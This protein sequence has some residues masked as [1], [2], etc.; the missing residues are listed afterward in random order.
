MAWLQK[1]RQSQN[2][3]VCIWLPNQKRKKMISTG[4]SNKKIAEK[5]LDRINEIE[6]LRKT[7]EKF[8]RLL[9][10]DIQYDKLILKD[11][12][13]MHGIDKTITLGA[14]S[15]TFLKSKGPKIKKGTLQSYKQSVNDLCTSLGNSKR[16]NEIKKQ[17]Y[18]ILLSFLMN[19]YVPTTVNIRQ[20]SIKTFF[21]WCIEYDYLD[22][23]PFKIKMLKIEQLPKFLMP[24][25][26][27]G[28]Y[29]YV[30]DEVMAAI[31]RMY[32]STGMRLSELYS[33]QYGGNYL[34]IVGKGGKV[35]FIPFDKDNEQNFQIAIASGYSTDKISRAFTIT[36]RKH[37]IHQNPQYLKGQ[38]VN[39]LSETDVKVI[40]FK[41]LESQYA[42]QIKKSKL[43]KNEKRIAQA[44][45][46]NLHCFRHTY[47]VR[48]WQETG[49]IYMVK[50]LLGHTG[51]STTEK[52]TRFPKEYIKQIMK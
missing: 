8:I 15:E 9:Y 29:K 52:Y 51:I 31:F 22:K 24:N 3:Y 23:M 47:A 10:T 45:G 35:R 39:E 34:E 25:E 18:D 37:L 40:A 16:I 38:N 1:L 36:W 11:I 49:D 50:N 32:E 19:K 17:D 5:I 6:N 26:I 42:K 12:D 14:A 13:E 41:I 30:G 20:R 44:S 46:K 43:S 4:T 28:I 7:E 48:K 21:N 27:N 2:Y 33:C